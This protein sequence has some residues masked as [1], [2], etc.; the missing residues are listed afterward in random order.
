PLA[1]EEGDIFDEIYF[2]SLEGKKFELKKI[3]LSLYRVRR[4]DIFGVTKDQKNKKSK[5]RSKSKMQKKSRS[6]NRKK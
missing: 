4:E 3:P 5:L 1:M 6:A 2:C